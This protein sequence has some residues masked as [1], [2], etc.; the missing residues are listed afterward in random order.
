MLYALYTTTTDASYFDFIYSIYNTVH[1]L[2]NLP[3]IYITSYDG[4]N[5]GYYAC[6]NRD[7]LGRNDGICW[8]M[9]S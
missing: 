8:T 6:F 4:V 2:S 9:E 7:V 1:K 5:F 3:S